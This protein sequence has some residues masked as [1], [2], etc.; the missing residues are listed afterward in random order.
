MFHSGHTDS[1]TQ[2]QMTTFFFL[3]L[4]TAMYVAITKFIVNFHSCSICCCC[5]HCCYTN[6][7]PYRQWPFWA[8]GAPPAP[9]TYIQAVGGGV[10]LTK[11]LPNMADKANN[12]NNNT[13]EQQQHC[14]PL[15]RIL[16]LISCCAFCDSEHLQKWSS[17]AASH[18]PMAVHS[19]EN[20]HNNYNSK[21]KSQACT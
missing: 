21:N 15:V 3:P 1:E 16:Q 17:A 20:K 18:S 4:I 10:Y 14:A 6:W 13:H 9:H 8:T 5:C 11:R 7:S 2:L 19:N 12:C